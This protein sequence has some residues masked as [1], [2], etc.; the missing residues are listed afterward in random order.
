MNRITLLVIMASLLVMHIAAFATAAF[1]K[2]LSR[3]LASDSV[4]LR[5]HGS[6]YRDG[7]VRWLGWSGAGWGFVGPGAKLLH[8]PNS[9]GRPMSA[10]RRERMDGQRVGMAGGRRPR[11]SDLCLPQ[12][13]PPLDFNQ[14]RLGKQLV[15]LS[16]IGFE[17]QNQ[18]KS[19]TG[20]R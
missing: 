9:I 11:C 15:L 4:T 16:Y 14:P 1:A 18:P 5:K 6:V 20:S 19:A 17:A 10:R 8:A 13:L 12:P 2:P 7:W 3:E